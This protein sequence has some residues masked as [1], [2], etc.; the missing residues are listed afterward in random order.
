[1]KFAPRRPAMVSAGLGDTHSG[2]S[3]RC[4]CRRLH[5]DRRPRRTNRR[6][7]ASRRGLRTSR[8]IDLLWI[9]NDP[10]HYQA[11]VTDCGWPETSFTTWSAGQM[12]RNLLDP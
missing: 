3:A 7:V 6:G 8:A 2:R 4:V 11:L 9:Y 10:A 12:R 5:P 1:M